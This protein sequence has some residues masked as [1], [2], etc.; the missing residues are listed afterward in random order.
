MQLEREEEEEEL[1]DKLIARDPVP[2]ECAVDPPL[3]LLVRHSR[4]AKEAALQRVSPRA[5]ARSPTKQSTSCCSSRAL[6][7]SDLRPFALSFVN[8]QMAQNE[9]RTKA[10]ELDPNVPQREEVP[11]KAKVRARSQK[12]RVQRSDALDEP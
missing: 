2:H 4:E 5:G 8:A 9:R 1:R 3:Q 12:G 10:G 7:V 11:A 6:A